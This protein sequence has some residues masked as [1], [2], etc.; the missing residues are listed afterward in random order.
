ME[1]NTASPRPWEMKGHIKETMALA[2][3]VIVG[4]IGHML[5]ASADTIMIGELGSLH[6]A[7]ASIAN[8]LFFLIAVIGIGVCGVISPL[9]A[10]SIGAEKGDQALSR[11]L[12]AGIIVA[13]W[14]TLFFTLAIWGLAAVIPWLGQQPESVPYAQSYLRILS[15]SLLPMLL[16]LAMKHFLDGFEAVVPGM[17][18]MAFMVVFHVFFNWVLIHGKLGF[19]AMGLDGA[20]W[21]TVVSRYLGLGILVGYVGA[22]KRFG[23]YF[24]LKEMFR[25][26]VEEIW[27]ILKIGIP[28][29]MQYFFEVGAFAG[30]VLLAGRISKEA[31]SAHQIAIQVASF[32]YMFYMG[33]AAAVSI[34]VGNAFGRRDFLSVRQASMAGILCGLGC[35]AV[36][37]SLMLGLREYLPALYIDEALVWGIAAK[38][39]MIAAVFQLFDGMQAIVMG[40]LR[41]M[42]DVT[43]P[44]GIT[45]VAYWLIGLPAAFV[46]VEYLG[47]GVEGIWYGL[48]IGL[49]FSALLLGWRLLSRTR[50]ARLQKLVD[51]AHDLHLQEKGFE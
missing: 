40:A 6:L 49:G 30:A 47:L 38:L 15:V 44:T 23:K 18:I 45:F 46:F 31:Q 32:T 36:F 2:G 43:L 16:F 7:A 35:V 29:G 11:R 19:P 12:H 20:G 22:S 27:Q 24:Q 14:M 1:M 50:T 34:R 5:I 10:Q 3:P 33:I 28:S 8:G 37:V 17:A 26:R 9:T 39:L 51:L 21:S 13:F 25:H 41:G 42:M 48:T 4:Q